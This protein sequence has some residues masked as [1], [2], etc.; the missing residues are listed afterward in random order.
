[1]ESVQLR[2]IIN[3]VVR[4]W[5]WFVISVAV[6]VGLAEYRILSTVPTYS[7]S[8]SILIKESNAKR[9]VAGNEI[10]SMFTTGMAPASKKMVNEI[11]T[12]QSPS[13]W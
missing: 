7:R 6:L 8:A 1:M 4:R 9:T 13:L 11:I 3:G 2:D 12:F 10:E 5:W